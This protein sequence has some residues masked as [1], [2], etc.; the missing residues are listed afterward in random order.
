MGAILVLSFIH[1][2][3]YFPRVT[4]RLLPPLD[5]F[6]LMFGAISTSFWLVLSH[7]F[8]SQRMEPYFY[9]SIGTAVTQICLSFLGSDIEQ[10]NGVALAYGFTHV[11]AAGVAFGIWKKFSKKNSEHQ[12]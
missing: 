7:Y 2:S 9:L 3:H 8:R 12:K 1:Y 11:G 10:V 5:Y 4:E 6:I